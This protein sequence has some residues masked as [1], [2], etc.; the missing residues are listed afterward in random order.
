MI[1]G[2][3]CGS[4]RY[5]YDVCIQGKCQVISLA[6]NGRYITAIVAWL[7][8]TRTVNYRIPEFEWLKLILTAVLMFPLD[9]RL[10]QLHLW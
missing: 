1:D 7:C 3:R 4:E 9:W 5:D 10:D 6:L 2:T 8:L